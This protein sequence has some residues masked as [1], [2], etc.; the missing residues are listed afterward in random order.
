[1]NPTLKTIPEAGNPL[2]TEGNIP[3]FART[4]AEQKLSLT[5]LKTTTLQVNM[6][7]LCNQECRH[8]H[9][10]AGPHRKELMTRETV[11]SVIATAHK[12]DFQVVD[13]TGGAP[14]LNPHLPRLIQGLF[15]LIPRILFRSNL[16][17]LNTEAGKGLPW[18]FSEHGVV[19][20]A[21][22]P[23]ANP[24]QTDAQRGPGVFQ[25]SIQGLQAL[26]ALGYGQEGSVLELNLVSNP[27]GAF[28]P[29]AQDQFEARFRQDLK[30]KWGVVFNH[31]YTLANVPLGRFLGWL[32][33]SNNLEPY[34]KK[35]VQSFNPQALEGVM[36]RTTV[37]VSWDGTLFDCD[38]N[39]ARGL[40]SGGK[41]THLSAM[42][43][44]IGPGMPIAV[45]DHCYACTA[46]SGFT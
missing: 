36:C 18:L 5:R 16:T 44:A 22:L 2:N 7:L 19:M 32:E 4:L 45:S 26:N 27:A 40:F 14:E 39:L 29:S 43:E 21:S 33:Q 15:P 25:K 35:L 46:G 20:I 28:L 17:A 42:K 8:C 24:D 41:K 12:E 10:E 11:E 9:L 13:I 38:F 34:L 6:G 30:E 1:M 31:L 3:G 23:A 37:S